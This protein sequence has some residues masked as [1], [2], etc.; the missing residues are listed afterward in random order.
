MQGWLKKTICISSKLTLASLSSI[1]WYCCSTDLLE[2]Q[3][4]PL[5][6]NELAVNRNLHKS[7]I[8]KVYG[9]EILTR[10]LLKQS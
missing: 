6:F 5:G 10:I 7:K 4:M 2:N 3:S 8:K 9:G 1:M